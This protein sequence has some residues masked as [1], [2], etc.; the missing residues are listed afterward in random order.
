VHATANPGKRKL[1]IPSAGG[2]SDN[3]TLML[4]LHLFAG[5]RKTFG[6][7]Y[8]A[9]QVT[10][11]GQLNVPG[12]LTSGPIEGKGGVCEQHAEADGKADDFVQQEVSSHREFLNGSHAGS[13]GTTKQGNA[14]FS[15]E[16]STA[17]G[18]ILQLD[19]R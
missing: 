16:I 17:G 10:G 14:S 12:D 19:S 4:Q 3:G 1:T 9:R 5:Q 7:A 15:L 8:S 6:G 13:A 18:Q 11:S 2:F